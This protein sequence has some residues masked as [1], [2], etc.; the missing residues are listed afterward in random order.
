ML[1]DVLQKGIIEQTIVIEECFAE[2]D[3]RSNNFNTFPMSQTL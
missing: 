3:N 1:K 2:G